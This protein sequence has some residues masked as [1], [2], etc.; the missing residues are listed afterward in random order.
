MNPDHPGLD[1]DDLA[2][3]IASDVN[4]AGIIAGRRRAAEKLLAPPGPKASLDAAWSAI[5]HPD[6]AIPPSEWGPTPD[7]QNVWA[8]EG[9]PAYF[10]PLAYPGDAYYDRLTGDVYRL[11]RSA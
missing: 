6:R 1:G 2:R 10:P 11:E 8:G 9:P 7:A 5:L 3:A 4:L